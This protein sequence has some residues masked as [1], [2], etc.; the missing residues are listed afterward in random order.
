MCEATEPKTFSISL[1]AWLAHRLHHNTPCRSLNEPYSLLLY[2]VEFPCTLHVCIYMYENLRWCDTLSV[3]AQE[4]KNSNQ[5]VG[6]IALWQT[7]ISRFSR[8]LKTVVFLWCL[9]VHFEKYNARWSSHHMNKSVYIL[10]GKLSFIVTRVL[11]CTNVLLSLT[12]DKLHFSSLIFT[13]LPL[14]CNR[15]RWITVPWIWKIAF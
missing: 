15:T 4:N 3:D 1:S 8:A 5:S 6:T 10:I 9:I 2:E 7:A 12:V 11:R 14:I 13:S